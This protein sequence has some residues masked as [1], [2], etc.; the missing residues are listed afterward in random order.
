M[1]QGPSSRPQPVAYQVPADFDKAVLGDVDLST[2]DAAELGLANAFWL[3]WM[4]LRKQARSM[5]LL[6]YALCCC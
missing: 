4:D 1:L 6:S 2:S 5:N 3:R